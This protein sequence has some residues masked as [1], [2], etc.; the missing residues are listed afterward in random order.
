MEINLSNAIKQSSEIKIDKI[1]SI[2]KKREIP[3]EELDIIQ[4]LQEECDFAGSFS[5]L[6]TDCALAYKMNYI[7]K[8][9]PDRN[10]VY[11]IMGGICH[12][13][14]EQIYLNQLS[15]REGLKQFREKFNRLPNFEVEF[16]SEKV[17]KNYE[18]DLISYYKHGNKLEEL[19]FIKEV[20]VIETKLKIEEFLYIVLEFND[21]TVG[22]YGY[23]DLI[24][25]I[26]KE[27]G[28]IE[29]IIGD[30]KTSS[31]N[32]YLGEKQKKYG[33]Q[34][35]LYSIMLSHMLKRDSYNKLYW[36]MLKY[37]DIKIKK[38]ISFNK[39]TIKQLK[40]ICEIEFPDF[41]LKSVLKK[42]IVKFLNKNKDRLTKYI[43]YKEE[44]ITG[45]ER[46]DMSK[47][48]VKV[49]NDFIE[50]NNLDVDLFLQTNDLFYAPVEIKNLVTISDYIIKYEDNEENRMETF[51]WIRDRVK[52]IK[53]MIDFNQFPADYNEFF[54]T[55]LCSYYKKCPVNSKKMKEKEAKLESLKI[56]PKK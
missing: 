45:V 9:E 31:K 3:K 10:S 21:F 47:Q 30:F 17:K 26:K 27:N 28:E 13:I 56:N 20:G 19:P 15:F 44:M 46:K 5:R 23:A 24:H 48:I 38:P 53:E 40:E 34:L 2:V 51:I 22:L 4:R 39:Y 43:K 1:E 7:D 54:C 12:D 16:P 50:E 14:N 52:I 29:Y 6:N 33:R 32:G 49:L 41:D 11:G 37:C 55:H 18:K 36:N 25:E 8:E 35:I 42:D